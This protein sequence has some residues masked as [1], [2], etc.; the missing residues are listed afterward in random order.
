MIIK[1]IK[2]L[3]FIWRNLLILCEKSLNY[4]KFFEF[5]YINHIFYKYYYDTRIK[6]I[7]KLNF[8]Y[9]DNNILEKYRC[10]DNFKNTYFTYPILFKT[11]DL[12]DNIFNILKKNH[13]Y[14]AIYWPINFNQNLNNHISDHILCIPIDQ[15]YDIND[16]KY[17]INILNSIN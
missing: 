6:D 9:I 12:R 4:L 3:K 10:L 14:C 15:R 7:R 5:D 13:I 8:E 17:I 1:N 11:K 2:F 16:M